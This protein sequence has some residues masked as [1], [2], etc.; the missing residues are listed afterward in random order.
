MC[1]AEKPVRQVLQQGIIFKD[2]D[3]HKVPDIYSI[4]HHNKNGSALT[5][6]VIV[7]HRAV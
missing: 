5:S 1:K 2:L 6:D 3:T 4:K 7:A